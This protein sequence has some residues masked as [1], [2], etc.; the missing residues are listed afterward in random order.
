[1]SSPACRVRCAHK[2]SV[3]PPFVAT[4]LKR[5]VNVSDTQGPRIDFKSGV[6][7]LIYLNTKY[8]GVLIEQS[9]SDRMVNRN[10]GQNMK[11]RS[12]SDV[13]YSDECW[14]KKGFSV[15]LKHGTAFSCSSEVL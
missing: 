10:K 4:L 9:D 6:A 14:T 3:V 11:R 12:L 7:K 8:I 2:E 1:M 5:N 15:S 13:S